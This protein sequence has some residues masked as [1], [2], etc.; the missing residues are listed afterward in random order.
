MDWVIVGRHPHAFRLA[1]PL[2]HGRALILC[3]LHV[4]PPSAPCPMS[5]VHLAHALGHARAYACTRRPSPCRSPARSC[6]ASMSSHPVSRVQGAP[7]PCPSPCLCIVHPHSPWSLSTRAVSPHPVPYP[8]IHRT[9]AI[10]HQ[11]G[12]H[13]TFQRAHNLLP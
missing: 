5:K 10:T 2:S 12:E 11:N 13:S 1:I 3:R 9:C 8:V 7:S 6:A 4:R